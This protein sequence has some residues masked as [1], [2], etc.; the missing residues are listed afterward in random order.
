MPDRCLPNDPAFRG[1]RQFM[2]MLKDPIRWSPHTLKITTCVLPP[3]FPS[4]SWIMDVPPPS[5]PFSFSLSL[6]RFPLLSK[7]AGDEG[8]ATEGGN[9]KSK[10][11]ESFPPSSPRTVLKSYSTLWERCRKASSQ[12]AAKDPCALRLSAALGYVDVT[13]WRW[14]GRGPSTPS[15]P[16]THLSDSLAVLCCTW[17]AAGNPKVPSPKSELCWT[18]VQPV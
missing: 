10:G 18:L 7:L 9:R 16:H 1:E 11:L 8:G 15:S 13:F 17:T 2:I 6:S 4:G 14:R 12:V 5:F 3:H